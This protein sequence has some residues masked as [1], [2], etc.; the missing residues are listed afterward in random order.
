[1]A[2]QLN[3]LNDSA[4]KATGTVEVTEAAAKAIGKYLAEHGAAP[5]SG[6]RIGVRGGGCSGLSYVLDV[7]AKARPTDHVI[8]AFGQRVFIDPKSMLFLQGSVF[9]YVTGLME[10][11]FKFNNPRASKACG[12]GESFSM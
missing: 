6:L 9:D 4:P 11:G 12:C 8:E 3:V 2:E 10:A 5:G 1:M 7:D